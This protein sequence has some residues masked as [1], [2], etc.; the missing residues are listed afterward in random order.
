MNNICSKKLKGRTY[1]IIIAIIGMGLCIFSQIV[2][3]GQNTVITSSSTNFSAN[4]AGTDFTDNKITDSFVLTNTGDKDATVSVYFTS[5]YGGLFG[6][7]NNTYVIGASNFSLGS[8]VWNTL[9]DDG[10]AA[11]L[12]DK[13]P[14]WSDTHYEARVRIP[15]GQPALDYVGIIEVLFS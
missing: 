5:N 7:V 3:A 4:K 2:A 6:M 8:T 10:T 9:N 11:F 1:M 12:I 14:A 15:P 13:V